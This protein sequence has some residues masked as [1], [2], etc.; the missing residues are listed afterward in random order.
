[1]IRFA[2]TDRALF[3]GNDAERYAAIVRQARA[4]SRAGVDFLQVREKDLG[5]MQ[6]AALA[7]IM[8]AAAR[9]AGQ[10][11]VLVNGNVA[12]A[13]D[14][15]GDGVHLP[16][17]M[18]ATEVPADMLASVSCHTLDEVRAA[19]ERRADLILFGPVFGKQVRDVPVSAG[20]GLDALRAAVAIAGEVPVIAL[21]GVTEANQQACIDAGAS[22]IAGIRMFLHAASKEA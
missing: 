20:L 1:M 9:S 6:L 3:P 13:V 5:A 17:A 12:A 14:G 4:L 2:I 15:G 7:R 10:M 11:K 16:A 22:G 19:V 18:A 8:V 21:G